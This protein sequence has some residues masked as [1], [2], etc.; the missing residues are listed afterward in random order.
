MLRQLIQT[1]SEVTA[2][3]YDAQ[4]DIEHLIDQAEK[5]IFEIAHSN[6]TQ[7]F[8]PMSAIVPRAFDRI[9]KLFDKQEHITGVA[10]GYEELDRMT[11]GCITSYNFV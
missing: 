11:A 8:H 5:T 3:C 1:T 9:T 7:G 4:D 2:R 10:T 6:K